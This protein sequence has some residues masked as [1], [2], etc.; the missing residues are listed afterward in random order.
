MT[1]IACCRLRG[2]DPQVISRNRLYPRLQF[3]PDGRVVPRGSQCHIE[4]RASSSIRCRDFFV[5]LSVAGSR[6]SIKQTPGYD[7][8]IAISRASD[9]ISTASGVLS[10]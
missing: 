9:T 3:Q 7:Y 8:G 6:D 5:S 1:G 10:R 4:D 2:R